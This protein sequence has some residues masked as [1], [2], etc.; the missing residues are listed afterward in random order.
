MLD[1]FLQTRAGV[2]GQ[3]S[4]SGRWRHKRLESVRR[5]RAV[6]DSSSPCRQFGRLQSLSSAL[7]AEMVLGSGSALL[8]KREAHNVEL[9]TQQ[10]HELHVRLRSRAVVEVHKRV[11]H[12]GFQQCGVL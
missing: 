1:H 3:R 8:L 5:R 2:D 4:A 6:N 12:T 7:I 9:V 10:T 11:P